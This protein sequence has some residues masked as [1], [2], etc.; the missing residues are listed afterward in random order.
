MSDEVAALLQYIQSLKE[1]HLPAGITEIHLLAIIAER[2]VLIE[3]ALFNLAV[4][5]R[6]TE[7]LA[8]A[9]TSKKGKRS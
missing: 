7:K 9:R 1:G 5:K 8:P 6:A 3:V 4:A 2:L